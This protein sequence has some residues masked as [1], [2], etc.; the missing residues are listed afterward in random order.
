MV[1]I[2]SLS[3]LALASSALADVIT[4]DVGSSGDVFSPNSVTAKD[5][6]IVQFNFHG[7]HSV[8]Q[9]DF[10]SP[11]SSTSN[12]AINSGTL[13]SGAFSVKINSTDP[14]WIFCG[15]AR[16][17]QSGMTMV[18]NPPSSGDTLEAYTQAAS[19]SGRSQSPS[20]VQGGIVGDASA[21]GT[22]SSSSSASAS[23][24]GAASGTASS[25]SSSATTTASS[26]S[27]SSTASTTTSSS[28]SSTSSGA[29][30]KVKVFGIAG[31][32][33]LLAALFA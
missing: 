4:V 15:Y 14:I 8:V 11:C 27:G 5:G 26:T 19:S 20:N 13:S 31:V 3:F 2:K 16:H 12:T 28:T 33:G 1:Q 6:D 22:D 23:A 32:A 17:C 29:A 24:S 25:G 18:I 21:F 30:E 7:T 9:S 10:S